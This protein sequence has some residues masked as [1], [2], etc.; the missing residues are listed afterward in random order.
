MPV[1][2]T[3]DSSIDY[4]VSGDGPPLLMIAGLGFG[5]WSWFKQVPALSGRFR[6]ITFDTRNVG[7]LDSGDGACSVSNL[8]V[9]ASALLEH[10]GIEQAHVLGTS[11]GGFVAQE[12]ALQRPELV[13]RL[14][15]ISTSYGGTKSEP[16][17]PQALGRMLGWG[18]VGRADAVRRGLEVATS[19]AY[20]AAH[21]EEFERMVGWRIADSPTIA[22]YSKQLLAGTRFDASRRVGRIGA[23]ALILHGADDRVVPV[24]NSVALAHELPD[25]KLRVFEDAGHL[26]FVERAEE[27]DEGTLAFLLPEAERCPVLDRLRARLRRWWRAL[28]RLARG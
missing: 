22:D 15:L 11:L 10:L 5:R 28:R 25:A 23:P 8:A 21:P 18:A 12:L 14:V 19:P 24:S 16:A 13:D 20:P 1:M 17:S 2:L 27:I 7:S 4:D 3:G 9:H 6:A 26:V